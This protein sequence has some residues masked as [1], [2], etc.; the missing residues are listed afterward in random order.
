MQRSILRSWS[1]RLRN[2]TQRSCKLW[3]HLTSKELRR[4]TS[5][6][7]MIPRN[8]KHRQL[9]LC[10]SRISVKFQLSTMS[11]PNSLQSLKEKTSSQSKSSK[12]YKTKAN[13]S[14][15]QRSRRGL[16]SHRNL[17]RILI[18]QLA[19]NQQGNR[20]HRREQGLSHSNQSQF[21]QSKCQVGLLLQ[22][23]VK[24]A[25]EVEQTLEGIA[26]QAVRRSQFKSSIRL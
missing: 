21:R 15:P 8:L 3:G 17:V 20:H 18:E 7:L 23:A 11:M 13:H 12:H 9:N 26:A 19:W 4:T 16:S 14:S 25:R 24:T 1:R 5:F 2:T 10:Q 22:E 6:K